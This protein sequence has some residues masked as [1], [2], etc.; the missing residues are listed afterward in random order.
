MVFFAESDHSNFSQKTSLQLDK[1][2]GNDH[3]VLP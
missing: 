2:E 3:K 1:L